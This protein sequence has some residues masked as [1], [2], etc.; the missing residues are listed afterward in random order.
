MEKLLI[1]VDMQ[2]DFV[3]GALANPAAAEI[4][5]GI[6]AEIES[7]S[8]DS[9]I[10]TRDTHFKNYLETQEGKNLPIPHCMLN[11]NG[12]EIVDELKSTIQYNMSQIV[13]K[14]TFGYQNW[15]SVIR[16]QFD[17]IVLVGT[18]TDI[19]VVS[20]ALILKALY[21]DT[22]ISVKENC[23]AGLSTEKHNAAIET[24]KSCQV[25]VY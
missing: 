19:C 18:C 6:K 2:N 12:H 1:V 22:I 17:E 11:T 23:C 8:Y 10:F 15:P 9:I 3:T 25:N 24:M 5:P 21:P 7:N 4:I 20:N 14:T 13:D 16:K